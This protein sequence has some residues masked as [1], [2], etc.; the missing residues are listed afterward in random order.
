MRV[1]VL[2]TLAMAMWGCG[3][4]KPRG[5]E[6]TEASDDARVPARPGGL[7]FDTVYASRGAD[8]SLDSLAIDSLRV[9]AR[10][11]D[12]LRTDSLR[13]DSIARAPA[14]PAAPAADFAAFWPRFQTAVRAGRE[15]TT[16]LTRFS[17]DLRREDFGTA[18][19]AAFGEP[20]RARVL[21]LTP[22]DFRRDGTARQATVVVGYDADGAIVPQDEAVTESAV[23]L[24]FDIVDGAYRMVSVTPTG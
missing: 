23:V 17:G 14:L 11:R 5:I 16:A 1:L 22:R 18:F 20:F 10:R 4:D 21:A 8:L 24:R 15:P 3:G 7:A 2:A 12:S 6:V 9:V 13:R 19:E